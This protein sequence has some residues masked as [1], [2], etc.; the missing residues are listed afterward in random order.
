MIDLNIGETE[1]LAEKYSLQNFPSPTRGLKNRHIIANRFS[2]LFSVRFVP[3][4]AFNECS[5]PKLTHIGVSD[6]YSS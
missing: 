3:L 2:C 4:I 1:K 5:I 6:F